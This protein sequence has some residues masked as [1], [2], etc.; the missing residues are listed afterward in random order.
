MTTNPFPPVARNLRYLQ[1][2]SGDTWQALARALDV[3]ERL[4]TAWKTDGKTVPSWPNIVKL[5]EH[6]GLPDPG[7][8]YLEHEAFAGMLAD[9]LAERDAREREKS[10]A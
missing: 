1:H 5:A 4:I 7:W 3:G 2:R 8:F 10:A 9:A 6:Y